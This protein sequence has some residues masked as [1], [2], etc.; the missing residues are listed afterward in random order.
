VGSGRWIVCPVNPPEWITLREATI[1]PGTYETAE[2]L[3]D[4]GETFLFLTPDV[5]PTALFG[6]PLSAVEMEAEVSGDEL[7]LRTPLGHCWVIHDEGGSLG[8]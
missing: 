5:R 2:V 6:V 4:L 8:N 7:R 3:L 1:P